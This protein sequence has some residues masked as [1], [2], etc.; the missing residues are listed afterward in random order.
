MHVLAVATLATGSE[1]MGRTIANCFKRVGQNGATMVEDGQGVDL[2]SLLRPGG[3]RMRT[4]SATPAALREACREGDVQLARQLL[5]QDVQVDH[6]A[7]N[8]WTPLLNA[9]WA[10]HEAC[11]QLL[12]EH[13]AAVNQAKHAATTPLFIA[14][15]YGHEACAR[16]LLERGAAMD[17]AAQDGIKLLFDSQ[18]RCRSLLMRTAMLRARGVLSLSWTP[19]SH[20]LYVEA[21]RLVVAK[22]G[23]MLHLVAMRMPAYRVN[24]DV[25]FE[26]VRWCVF[27]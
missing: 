27:V 14:F 22:V 17:Q 20:H 8:G 12:L 9:C 19:G 25:I 15:F 3:A 2:S 4:R 21:D 1:G 23:R 26:V 16:L 10:G 11:A 7:P 13:G 24:A 5:R 18:G 6:A